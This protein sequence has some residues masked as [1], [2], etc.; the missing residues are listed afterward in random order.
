[1]SCFLPFQKLLTKMGQKIRKTNSSM[2]PKMNPKSDQMGTQ[3]GPRGAPERNLNEE[4]K[5][6]QNT[7]THTHRNNKNVPPETW[8]NIEREVA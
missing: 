2:D 8:E 4:A 3:N 7:N 1:M 5:R 6:E